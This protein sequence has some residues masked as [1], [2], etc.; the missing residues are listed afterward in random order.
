MWMK[1]IPWGINE[2][3]VNFEVLSDIKPDRSNYL[4]QDPHGRKDI[5]G[6]IRIRW[7]FMVCPFPEKY[8]LVG[9]DLIL[10][11]CEGNPCN[12]QIK[13]TEGYGGLYEPIFPFKDVYGDR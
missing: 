7:G 10:I 3:S 11:L 6:V 9:D 8:P 4:W 12:L 13:G 1:Y 5:R 2:A